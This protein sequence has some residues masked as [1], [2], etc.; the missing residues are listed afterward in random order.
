MISNNNVFNLYDNLIDKGYITTKDIIN[1][2]FTKYDID[3]L[4]KEEIIKR[5]RRGIYEINSINKLLYYGRLLN[6]YD[7]WDDAYTYFLKAHELQPGN[8][9]ICFQLFLSNIQK[10]NF[11]EAFKFFDFLITSDNKFYNI[12]YNL[13]LYLLSFVTDLPDKYKEYARYINLKDITIPKSDKRYSDV[14]KYNKVRYYIINN[15]FTKAIQLLY[16][17]VDSNGKMTIQDVITSRLLNYAIKSRKRL[18]NHTN[19]FIKEKKYE[20]L[21]SLYSGVLDRRK[22]TDM[23]SYTLYIAKMIVE[24]KRTNIVPKIT[25]CSSN[26][27]HSALMAN[28][29]NTALAISNKM[30]AKKKQDFNPINSLLQDLCNLIHS[31]NNN[32]KKPVIPEDNHY[33]H[34]KSQ[35]DDNFE[36]CSQFVN[37]KYKTLLEKKGIII[38]SPFTKDKTK[39]ILDITKEKHN[40]K[41]FTVLIDGKMRIILKYHETL[42]EDIHKS[43]I[44]K[45]AKEAYKRQ[46]YNSCIEKNL[47]LLHHFDVPKAYIFG[48]IGLSYLKK[49]KVKLAKEYLTVADALS[50]QGNEK[51][52][53]SQVL[54]FL[55]GEIHHDDLKTR[56]YFNEEE[57]EFDYLD[58]TFG[59]DN[60]NELNDYILSTGMDV[61][62][63]CIELGMD[64]EKIQIIKLIYAREYYK[65]GNIKNGD[66]F[67]D[68]V[69]SA[70]EN[71]ER[72][73][74]ILDYIKRNKNLLKAKIGNQDRQIQL[75][76]TLYPKA[77]E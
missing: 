28:D 15:N 63:A 42:D 71:S 12:D 49:K 51:L 1:L 55:N 25:S 56:V 31:I 46:D 37:R 7:E 73:L 2:G 39:K 17:I 16:E 5:T 8:L 30:M 10:R 27:L 76:L 11:S 33:L 34:N 26:Y 21:I 41:A 65:L 54:S 19:T 13:Y 70:D 52:D 6:S 47:L 58:S 68:S 32:R 20:D 22:L 43:Q 48:M 61:E 38:L 53:Y 23:E 66:I 29:F 72:V 18:I 36:S 24:I 57:F 62:S 64:E 35:Y 59:I 50:K 45:D 77:K 75:S 40:V 9:S 67:I 60:F 4:L 44:I 3:I 74:K 14:S 69:E